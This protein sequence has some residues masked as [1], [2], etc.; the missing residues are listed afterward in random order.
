MLRKLTVLLA[1]LSM[2]R[3]M[4]MPVA[5]AAG[6]ADPN[7]KCYESGDAFMA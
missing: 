3:V 5:L 7:P 6:K 4:S 2:M 1:A